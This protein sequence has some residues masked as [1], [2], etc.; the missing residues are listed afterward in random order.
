MSRIVI[1]T[2]KVKKIRVSIISAPCMKLPERLLQASKH[3][4]LYESNQIHIKTVAT[5]LAC[6]YHIHIYIYLPPNNPFM[7]ILIE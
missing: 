3:N 2:T 7:C 4:P 5:D 1:V 6:V